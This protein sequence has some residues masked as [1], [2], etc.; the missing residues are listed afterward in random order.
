VARMPQAVSRESHRTRNKNKQTNKPKRVTID[1][2]DTYK[3]I[4]T[5]T[6]SPLYQTEKT[7]QTTQRWSTSDAFFTAF[8]S[9]LNFISI[10]ESFQRWDL[11][12]VPVLAEEY[13][14]MCKSFVGIGTS[15]VASLR[16]FVCPST[17]TA[18]FGVVVV[19]CVK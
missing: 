2:L 14:P 1:T 13:P 4:F 3:H 10:S 8:F 12:L 17:R 5:Q 15:R 18:G 11:D 9:Q 16:L 7:T 6:L 19:V